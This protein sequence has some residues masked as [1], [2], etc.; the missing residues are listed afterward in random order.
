MHDLNPYHPEL[1]IS[2]KPRCAIRF[3]TFCLIVTL[4]LCQKPC[5]FL[6]APRL[7][8]HVLK[9][10]STLAEFDEGDIVADDWHPERR[11]IGTLR[12][13]KEMLRKDAVSTLEAA[14]TQLVLL[15]Y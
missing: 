14:L 13:G 2:S 4:N 5:S 15:A 11:M 7:L 9:V 10:G 6:Y 8:E 12:T 1:S 3:R